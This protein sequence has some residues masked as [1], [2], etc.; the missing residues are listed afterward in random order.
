MHDA[1]SDVRVMRRYLSFITQEVVA[2]AD[3]LGGVLGQ[4]RA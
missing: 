3:Q 4:V 2:A 1:A